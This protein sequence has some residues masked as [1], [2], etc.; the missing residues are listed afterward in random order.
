M[1]SRHAAEKNKTK[2]NKTKNRP[3]DTNSHLAT[4]N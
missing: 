4:F 3:Q 2:K 1:N